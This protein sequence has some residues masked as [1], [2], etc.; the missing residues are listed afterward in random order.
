[1]D[2][3]VQ[4]CPIDVRRPLYKVFL[5][6][7]TFSLK[8]PE[9]FSGF[10]CQNIVLSGGSTMFRDFGRRMQRDI[11]RNVDNRLNISSQLSG[12]KITVKVASI[13]ALLK[14]FWEIRER[15]STF[16]FILA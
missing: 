1:V 15:I 8:F 12:G 9:N 14:N 3:V 16:P 6:F 5:P 4:N 11:K 13:E 2:D 7:L 10:Y